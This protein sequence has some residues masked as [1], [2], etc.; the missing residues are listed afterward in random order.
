MGKIK[1][2]FMEIEDDDG[3]F[4]DDGVEVFADSV[5]Q[6]LELASRE[7]GVDIHDLDY[8][9]L[10]KGTA[11]LFGFGRIPYRVIV[12]SIGKATQEHDDL[13]ELEKKLSGDHMP[14]FH[15]P[16]KKDIDS[17]FKIRVTKSGVWLIVTPAKGKGR[18]IN[19]GEVNNKLFSMRINDAEL[20]KVESE[21][22]KPSGKPV[23]IGKW[24]P[25]QDF[26][27]SMNIE[28]SEDEMKCFIHFHPPRF[29][30]RH[31]EY[32][33]VIDG[34]K[35]S[36]VIAGIRHEKIREYLENMDYALPLL[37]AEGT[38]ARNGSDAFVDYK[39]RVDKGDLSFKEDEKGNV[40][41]REKEV[42]ENAVIGQL[43]A[44]KVPAEEGV[45]GRTVR[46]RIL[47]AR[48]GKDIKLQHGKGTILSEDGNELT[49]EINGQVVYKAGK[50]SIEEVFYVK[51]DVSLETGNIVFLGSVIIGGGVQ[52]NFSVK[53]AGNV[54]VRG[55][56]QKAYIESEGDIVIRGGIVGRDEARIESTGGSVIAKFVQSTNIFAEKDVI[57]P[58]GIMHSRVDAGGGIFCTGRRAKIMG[59]RIRAGKEV[60]ARFLG[61]EASTKTEIRVGI[62]PKVLQQLDDLDA[63]MKSV[64]D[65]INQLKPNLSTLTNQKRVSRL[66]EEKQKLFD[67]LTVQNDRLAARMNEL[68]MEHE[69]LDGYINMLEHKGKI[70]AE[71]SAFPGVEIFIKDKNFRIRDEYKNIK[72]ALEG[73]EIRLSSYEPPQFAEG[74][75]K[76]R[77]L[78]GSR[79]K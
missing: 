72:F 15:I 30:G 24:T 6:A 9:I 23:K 56:V 25:N 53:A 8:D 52:D 19:L 68:K 3:D 26:D 57:V 29:S 50:I 2:L 43:L 44:V 14:S 60:N 11:G 46:N 21:V 74:Q 16:E 39:V 17:T 63:A 40:D 4:G 7:L 49:A 76:I 79:R 20:P 65:E 58:E 38:K 47:P 32:D 48:A 78:V 41:F 12:R 10:E 66:S 13:F 67:D 59:G 45:T 1:D 77:T 75:Q 62:H 42:L 27:S 22:D 28:V 31:L 37:A 71:K 35:R 64:E 34:L 61:G 18:K 33:E 55:I 54:E 5:K 70:C 69:E 73:G 51:G 36:G